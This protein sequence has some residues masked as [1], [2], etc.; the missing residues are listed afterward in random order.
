M[1]QTLPIPPFMAALPGVDHRLL[2]DIGLDADGN[3]LNPDD[4]RLRRQTSARPLLGRVLQFL[5]VVGPLLPTAPHA[6]SRA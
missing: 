3:V 5:N 4:P 2:R 6:G 1:T